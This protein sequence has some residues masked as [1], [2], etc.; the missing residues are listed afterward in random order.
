LKRILIIEDDPQIATIERDYL[1]RNDYE[2]DIAKTGYDGITMAKKE[3]YNLILLDL[4][5][6]GTEGLTV[7]QHLRRIMD[8]PIIMVTSQREDISRLEGLSIGIDDFIT[9]PIVSEELI[10]HVSNNITMHEERVNLWKHS[11]EIHIGD[12]CIHTDSHR[13][14]VRDKDAKIKS[15]EYELLM[16]LVR[17]AN[18][19]FNKDTLYKMIWGREGLDESSLIDDYIKRLREKLEDEPSSPKYIQTVWSTYYRFTM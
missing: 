5:L 14:Y 16:F 4:M 18:I 10:E 9:K 15:K 12:L 8:I 13:V 17:N 1:A 3:T 6:P 11:K 19:V 2:I 7:C